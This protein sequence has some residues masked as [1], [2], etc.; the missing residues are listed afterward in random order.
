MLTGADANAIP[1]AFADIVSNAE[2]KSRTHRNDTPTQ[3][4]TFT[5]PPNVMMSEVFFACSFFNPAEGQENRPYA[6][7]S[8]D[9]S[10]AAPLIGAR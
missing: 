2:R 6:S 3:I 10:N 1:P 4:A 5:A 8:P 9:W 7:S